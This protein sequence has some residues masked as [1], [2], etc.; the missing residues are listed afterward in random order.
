MLT[1]KQT[2]EENYTVYTFTANNTA[3]EVVTYDNVEYVVYSKR[4]TLS[5]GS[6]PKVYDNLEDMAKRSKALNQLAIL[7]AA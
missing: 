5:Q 3:Y 1:I 4:L 7:I 2:I 6:I